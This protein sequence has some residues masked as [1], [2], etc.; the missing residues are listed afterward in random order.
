MPIRKAVDRVL[1]LDRRTGRRKLVRVSRRIV[2]QW[3]K[4]YDF[5]VNAQQAT[6]YLLRKGVL[7][8]GMIVIEY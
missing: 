2:D 4:D 6:A 5:P 3:G 8:D 7:E 1:V